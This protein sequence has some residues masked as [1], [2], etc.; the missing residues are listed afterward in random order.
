MGCGSLA[1]AGPPGQPCMGSRTARQRRL[2]VRWI[3]ASG[4]PCRLPLGKRLLERRN[5][6]SR[7]LDTGSRATGLSLDAR[8][9]VACRLLGRRTL[10]THAPFWLHVG[11]RT[12]EIRP[13]AHG[14]LASCGS[15]FRPCLGKW[16][17]EWQ[18][19]ARRTMAGEIQAGLLLDRRLSRI[20]RLGSWTLDTRRQIS[21]QASPSSPPGPPH[22]DGSQTVRAHLARRQDPTASGQVSATRAAHR[23][24][25][26]P[27]YT[28]GPAGS[29]ARPKS[30]ASRSSYR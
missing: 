18:P 27:A 1:A 15:A 9:L 7:T 2:L 28:Q 30:R 24:A 14:I 21:G 16:T 11:H 29:T 4:A 25:R 8:L 17:L 3:L 6:D 22:E 20:Q 19:V 26:R 13:L 23:T 12:V 10:A 5:M